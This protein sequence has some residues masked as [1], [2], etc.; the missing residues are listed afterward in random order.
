MSLKGGLGGGGGA[1]FWTTPLIPLGFLLVH[2]T[3]WL[4][5]DCTQG[6]QHGHFRLLVEASFKRSCKTVSSWHLPWCDMC[7]VTRPS[8]SKRRASRARPRYEP[9]R[10]FVLKPVLSKMAD[11]P[12]HAC[13]PFFLKP[14]LSNNRRW[15]WSSATPGPAR[16]WQFAVSPRVELPIATPLTRH[17]A[18]DRRTECLAASGT[19]DFKVGSSWKVQFSGCAFHVLLFFMPFYI[20]MQC[21]PLCTFGTALN[22]AYTFASLPSSCPSP[23]FLCV[24]LQ[25][26]DDIKSLRK[27]LLHLT[28]PLATST[29]QSE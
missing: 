2:R 22:V 19:A 23:A 27:G 13:N 12:N 25:A 18:A 28:Q 7:G 9:H 16:L 14:V 17:S 26:A 10:S 29:G 8:A 5:S 1:L 4:L 24:V 3:Y 11:R 15:K 6:N 20:F 21:L